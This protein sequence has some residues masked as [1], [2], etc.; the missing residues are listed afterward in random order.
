MILLRNYTKISLVLYIQSEFSPE[1]WTSFTWAF[2][3]K[4][5]V[6]KSGGFHVYLVS[7]Y[8]LLLLL[9]YPKMQSSMNTQYL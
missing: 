2:S 8:L 4:N 3:S 9:F 6:S 5:F 1:P 7:S